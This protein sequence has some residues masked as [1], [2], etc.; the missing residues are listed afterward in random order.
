MFDLEV[1]L[2]GPRLRPS[3]VG[4]EFTFFSTVHFRYP[5]RVAQFSM[6]VIR[7]PARYGPCYVRRTRDI[8]AKRILKMLNKLGVGPSRISPCCLVCCRN[9]SGFAGASLEGPRLEYPRHLVP[10]FCAAV[11]HMVRPRGKR[12]QKNLML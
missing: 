5:V 12:I 9:L 6:C 11:P 4:T 1:E 10:C 2:Q 8:L 7:C 3:L